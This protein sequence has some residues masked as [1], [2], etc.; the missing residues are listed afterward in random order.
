MMLQSVN[1]VPNNKG[2][3]TINEM[4]GGKEARAVV[5]RVN[6]ADY[7]AFDKNMPKRRPRMVIVNAGK[8]TTL[9]IRRSYKR[10]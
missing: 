9:Y 1:S 3:R 8:G 4:L 10:K 5:I 6:S 2:I 7:R